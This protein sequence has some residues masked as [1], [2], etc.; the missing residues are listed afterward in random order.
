MVQFLS[1]TF[2]LQQK[3]QFDLI[4]CFPKLVGILVRATKPGAKKKLST[5]RE[6]RLLFVASDLDAPKE[7]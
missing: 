6:I 7:T 4:F 1:V 5:A 2:P 3:N